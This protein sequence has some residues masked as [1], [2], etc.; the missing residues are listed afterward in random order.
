MSE[1]DSPTAN[2]NNKVTVKYSTK[3]KANNASAM[4]QD[5]RLEQ[6]P[7][8]DDVNAWHQTAEQL[9][10]SLSA[11]QQADN[12]VDAWQQSGQKENEADAWQR[13]MEPS[14]KKEPAPPPTTKSQAKSG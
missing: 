4:V 2:A 14:T 12:D 10:T 5:V 1:P 8:D 11:G 9:K 3:D 6:Q 13:T 7:V